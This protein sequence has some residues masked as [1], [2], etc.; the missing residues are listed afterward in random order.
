MS[1]R[2]AEFECESLS[3]YPLKG[4]S[5]STLSTNKI[6]KHFRLP[7][8]KMARVSEYDIHTALLFNYLTTAAA[9]LHSRL[10]RKLKKH[11]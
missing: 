3:T 1:C 11:P 5:A 7:H 9:L 2:K 10:G 4:S 6:A 8:W